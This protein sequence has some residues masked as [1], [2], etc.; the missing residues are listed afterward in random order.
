MFTTPQVNVFA[1]DV[2]RS[3][4]FYRRFGFIE[5]FR[6]PMS[7]AP[8]HVELVLDGL[9]LGIGSAEAARD[10]HGLEVE[11]GA[12]AMSVCLWTDDVASSYDSLVAAGAPSLTPPHDLAGA[13]LRVARIADPDGNIVELVQH[14]P[15]R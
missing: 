7:G 11:P 5:T 14:L 4:R 13:D 10:V 3:A 6:T 12:R 2:D 9:K 1:T 15:H 8:A